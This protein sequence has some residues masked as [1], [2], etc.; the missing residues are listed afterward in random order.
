[1]A[2]LGEELADDAL[3]TVVP[4]LAEMVVA[5]APPGVDEIVG[6]LIVIVEGAPERIVV[7]E[8]DRIGN[9]ELP[10]RPAYIFGIALEREFG[11]MDAD[12]DEPVW[13]V[14]L[15]PGLHRAGRAGS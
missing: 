12:D 1:M 14:A 11:R 13:P 9:A 8:R 5:H 2:G 7:V 3:G 10:D 15:G 4:A 6:G